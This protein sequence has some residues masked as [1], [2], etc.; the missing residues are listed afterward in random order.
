MVISDDLKQQLFSLAEK[1]KHIRLKPIYLVLL[2]FLAVRAVHIFTKFHFILWDEAV[3]IGIGKFLFSSG[4]VGL[5]EVIRPLGLPVILGFLWFLGLKHIFVYD[6]IMLAFSLGSIYLV[7]VIV[8]RMFGVTEGVVASVI[9][10]ITPVFFYNSMRILTEIPS[11]FFLLLAIYFLIR[12]RVFQ[13]GLSAGIAFMFKFTNILLF[14]AIVIILL[15]KYLKKREMFS[16]KFMLVLAGFLIAVSPY[17][18]LNQVSY[19]NFLEPIILASL[20]GNNPVHA[21]HDPLLNTFYYPINLFWDNML[22]AFSLFSLLYLV[23]SRNV[24]MF[25]FLATVYM[26][27]FAMITNKQL[28]FAITFLPFLSLLASVGMVKASRFVMRFRRGEIIYVFMIIVVLLFSWNSLYKDYHK[29]HS[30]PSERP[31][32]VGEHYEYFKGMDTN[33]TILTSDPVPVAYS[34]IRMIPYYSNIIDAHIIYDRYVNR[35]D[36]VVFS[37]NPFPCFG[38]GCE[39]LKEELFAKIF[40]NN[41][42]VSESAYGETKYIFRV[43]KKTETAGG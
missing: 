10:A 12:N 6:L 1:I 30:F 41:E 25:V 18:I 9:F 11:T 19:G 16:R 21:V 26:F 39:L 8:K 13:S 29:F 32:I 15:F 22:L 23:K 7:Y 28:R 38:Y 43:V 40:E 3:Y 37:G 24:R 42:L 14:P 17:V 36:Y 34:D 20:H 35:S 5:F 33:I 31:A 27:V 4:S 2:V